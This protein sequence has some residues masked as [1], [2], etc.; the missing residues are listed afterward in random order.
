MMW[1]MDCATVV[2]DEQ[3]VGWESYANFFLQFKFITYLVKFQDKLYISFY[4]YDNYI[5]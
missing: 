3:G 2:Q 5:E 1:M 4:A